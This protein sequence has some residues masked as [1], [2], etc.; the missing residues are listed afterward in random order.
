MNIVPLRTCLLAIIISTYTPVVNVA[1]VCAYVAG[2]GVCRRGARVMG[3]PQCGGRKAVLG[4]GTANC[5]VA[6]WHM[7]YGITLLCHSQERKQLLA[8]L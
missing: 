6:V 5:R 7:P 2:H 8:A 4:L 3:A 1:L